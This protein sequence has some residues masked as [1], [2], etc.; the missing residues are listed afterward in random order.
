MAIDQDKLDIG[1]DQKQNSMLD[2]KQGFF[3]PSEGEDGDTGLCV[4]NGIRYWGVK[5]QNKWHFTDLRD[6]LDDLSVNNL[7]TNFLDKNFKRYLDRYFKSIVPRTFALP[8]SLTAF[9]DGSSVWQYLY[10][11]T[12]ANHVI[13]GALASY[14]AYE[15]LF[16]RDVQDSHEPARGNGMPFRCQLG[17]DIVGNI[18]GDFSTAGNDVK[19]YM[20]VEEHP[21]QFTAE[22]VEAKFYMGGTE[23][24]GSVTGMSPSYA[25]AN[26]IH[27]IIAPQK[28]YTLNKNDISYF[29]I[30]LDPPTGVD[31]D[32]LSGLLYFEEVL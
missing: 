8:F 29:R 16:D 11:G 31:V 3:S 28:I 19:M 5:S 14:H 13:F 6:S 12:T 15:E 20:A 32:S 17:L 9:E 21:A 24:G 10:T 25:A 7:I 30:Y 1:L 26:A 23:A 22:F 18:S 2:I 27:Y 4:N